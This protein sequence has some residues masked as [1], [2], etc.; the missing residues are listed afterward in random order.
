MACFKM[1]HQRLGRSGQDEHNILQANGLLK[2][3]NVLIFEG[4]SFPFTI[5][6][7]TLFISSDEG[8]QPDQQIRDMLPT[9]V[10]SSI[11][12]LSVLTLFLGFHCYSVSSFPLSAAALKSRDI[13]NGQSVSTRVVWNSPG[14]TYERERKSAI[15]APEFEISNS[16]IQGSSNRLE[17]ATTAEKEARDCSNCYRRLT[18]EG[19]GNTDD[20]EEL[21]KCFS[22]FLPDIS[23]KFRNSTMGV[24][25]GGEEP[26]WLDR[27]W[28]YGTAD[29]SRLSVDLE[30]LTARWFRPGDYAG[31]VPG[32]SS[33]DGLVFCNMNEKV[34]AGP[35]LFG[36]WQADGF[37]EGWCDHLAS[38]AFIVKE[39][40][41]GEWRKIAYVRTSSRKNPALLPTAPGEK[42]RSLYDEWCTFI[43]KEE[44]GTK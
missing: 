25:G 28:H 22:D 38:G 34:F 8:A 14:S 36:Y 42:K 26:N 17:N 5:P 35:S 37:L 2:K 43:E 4:S 11:K 40:F 30:P 39:R 20:R 13:S 16:G 1:V 12:L 41:G 44:V 29:R 9:S 19:R 21:A 33:T 7:V 24:V 18:L 6:L 31:Y 32:I 15:S 3:G 27:A 10:I 23:E